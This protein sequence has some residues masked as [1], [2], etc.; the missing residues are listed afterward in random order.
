MQQ[1]VGASFRYLKQ[2]ARRTSQTAE[3][4]HRIDA[5]LLCPNLSSQQG[6][7]DEK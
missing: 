4:S 1:T 2:P 6:H 5:G 7:S 3:D